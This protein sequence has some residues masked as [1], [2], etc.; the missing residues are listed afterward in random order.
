VVG[1]RRVLMA[2]T[3]PDGRLLP[4]GLA[5]SNGTQYLTTVVDKGQVFLPNVEAG[6]QLTVAMSDNQTC[7]L[8]F[9][10][11]KNAENEG[12]FETVNAVCRTVQGQSL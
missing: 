3:F 10:L 12:Y 8:D 4:K 9:T 5:V 1:S 6:A 11:P 2:A 7:A